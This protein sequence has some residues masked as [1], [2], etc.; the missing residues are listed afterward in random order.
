MNDIVITF[1]KEYDDE[2]SLKGILRYIE[3]SC[4]GFNEIVI[5]GDKPDWIQG[6][7]YIGFSSAEN[8]KQ[9]MKNKFEKLKAV[10]LH[11]SVTKAFVWIDCD[12]TSVMFS[13]YMPSFDARK[14]IRLRD[15]SYEMIR[16]AYR[17]AL[18]RTQ[19]VIKRRG[20]FSGIYFNNNPITFRKDRLLNTFDDYDFNSLYGYCIKTLYVN[21][22]RL[23]E[24][25]QKDS[26]II[27]LEKLEK[28]S[29]YEKQ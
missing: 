16:S 20:F 23:D 13:K 26:L 15:N 25:V 12:F 2:E 8:F 27:N 21:Y 9:R 28:K 5:V 18:E 19:K 6:V 24:C 10:C 17:I 1:D 11:K 3:S 7:I 22:N 4:V 29:S 14:P